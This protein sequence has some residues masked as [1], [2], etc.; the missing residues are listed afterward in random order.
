VLA[1]ALAFTGGA[2]GG[3]GIGA[4]TISTMLIGGTFVALAADSADRA[5]SGALASGGFAQ[6]GAAVSGVDETVCASTTD[7]VTS[8]VTTPPPTMVCQPLRVIQF[9]DR[10]CVARRSPDPNPR[11]ARLDWSTPLRQIYI[12]SSKPAQNSQ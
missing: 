2:A 3:G 1:G 6:S 8:S 5:H 9:S 11:V 4:G 12:F 7:A 10:P